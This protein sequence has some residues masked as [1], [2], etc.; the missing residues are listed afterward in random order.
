MFIIGTAGHVDHGKT[1]LIKALTGIDTDRLPEEKKRGMTI[2]LGFAHF[3]SPDGTEIGVVD[4]PGHERFIRN[5]TAGAWGIDLAL[6]VIAADDGWMYQTENH[7]RVLHAMGINDIIITVTKTDTVPEE[8]VSDVIAD[9]EIRLFD[10]TEIA[11][12][13]AAVSAL[14]GDGIDDLKHLIIDRLQLIRSRKASNQHADSGPLLWVDRAF[15]IKGTGLVVTGSLREGSVKKND[16]LFMLPMNLKVRVRGIQTYDSETETAEPA[17]RTALNLSGIDAAEVKRGCCLTSEHSGFSS[18]T[19]IIIRPKGDWSSIRNH[20][21]AEFASGTAHSI[22]A[23]HFLKDSAGNISAGRIVL[24]QALPMRFGQPVVIIRKGGSRITGSGTVIWTGAIDRSGKTRI[25]QS[26]GINQQ[27]IHLAVK[28]FVQNGENWIFS[29]E[30]LKQLENKLTELASAAGG[31]RNEELYG[32]FDLPEAALRYLINELKAGGRLYE[33]DGTIFGKKSTE[34]V[35]S[36]TAKLIMSEAE[37]AGKH[38]LDLNKT[39]IPGAQKE[40]RALT[41]AG[42]IIPLAENL[43]LASGVM[44]ELISAVLQGMAPNDTFDIAHTKERTGLSRKYIIPLLNKMEEKGL[45]ER[46]DN[47]RRIIRLD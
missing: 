1:L 32:K 2:D 22:G 11:A 41:R 33:H 42:L 30:K 35:L 39:R 21:E 25:S 7:L 47:L 45:V 14:N 44:N 12:P 37:R 8:R 29:S 13:S 9:A 46:Q 27:D 26:S 5:M 28:G 24:E 40:L 34:A 6:L 20:S 23:I 3:K 4:V 36:P 18:E 19:E 10:M 43:F 38:G 15:G 31:I 17:C 16:T